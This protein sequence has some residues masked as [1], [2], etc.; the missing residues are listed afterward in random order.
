MRRAGAATMKA[1]AHGVPLL[2]M[3]V[4][5]TADQRLIGQTLQSTGLGRWLPK[6]ARP[7]VIRDTVSALLDDAALRARADAT[8]RRLRSLPPGAEVAAERIVSAAGGEAPRG[9]ADERG[10]W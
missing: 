5:P 1:L 9:R 4:N 8:G 7:A 6:N 10:T 2:V 3:P